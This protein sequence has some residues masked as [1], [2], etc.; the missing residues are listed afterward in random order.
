MFWLRW[1]AGASAAGGFSSA[2]HRFAGSGEVLPNSPIDLVE[3]LRRGW[4]ELWYQPKIDICSFAISGVEALIRLRHP[5][6]GIVPPAFFI[7]DHGD[8]DFQP[9]S[10]FVLT[11]ALKD[12]R[13]FASHHAAFD[14]AINLPMAFFH[15]AEATKKLCRH[16]PKHPR[17]ERLIVEING[18]ELVRNINHLTEGAS[19][20]RCHKVE[21]SIDDVGAEWPQLA[22][23]RDL[24]IAELKVD[25]KFITG[26]A[27]SPLKQAICRQIVDLANKLHVRTV[28]EGVETRADFSAVTEMGFH[29]VQ[30]FLFAEPMTV[31]KF[32]RATSLGSFV[33]LANRALS[34]H[35]TLTRRTRAD[36]Y[37]S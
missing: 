20:L 21:I 19:L 27:K 1:S 16:L 35:R 29:L 2:A 26:C 24:P 6:W 36:V 10:E 34:A 4:F 12:W 7:P 18:T 3:S 9:L 22:G 33:P 32:A 37:R 31:Q 8:P 5:I 15:D 14:I 28:A 30:G 25:R 17:F 11:Q 13:Y 23:V